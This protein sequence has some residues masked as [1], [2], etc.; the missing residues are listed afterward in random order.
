M[1]CKNCG[2]KII[3]TAHFCEHCGS[4]VDRVAE[5]KEQISVK[6][7]YNNSEDKQMVAGWIIVI[8]IIISSVILITYYSNQNDTATGIGEVATDTAGVSS[9]TTFYTQSTANARSCP[10]KTCDLVGKY[11][12]NTGFDLAYKSVGDLPDWVEVSWQDDLGVSK[13]GYISKTVLSLS[14]VVP[15]DSTTRTSQQS[16]QDS[17]QQTSNAFDLPSIVKEW[18]PR[19]VR[20]VCDDDKYVSSGSGVLTR[21][22][23]SNINKPNAPTL[24]TNKH[25][26]TDPVSGNLFTSCN[27]VVPGLSKYY[28]IDMSVEADLAD[29]DVAYFPSGST[30]PPPA[31]STTLKVCSANDVEVGDKIAILGYPVNGG[32]GNAS[33]AIT[34]TDGIVS[35]YDGQFYVTNAKI[36]H[37]NSG[38]AAILLKDDCYLGIPTW[39]QSGGFESFGRILSASNVLSRE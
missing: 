16:S 32:T 39:A 2:Q 20:I 6:S 35:S 17:S 37:G 25:V 34:L 10:S 30:D 22:D 29:E 21:M 38:G 3:E 1:Y 19:V 36:D 12:A 15:E 26:I 14:Q 4:A 27:F 9:N 23:W 18:S 8:A 31:A 7:R 33:T 11:P 5:G 13:T 28:T 24:I